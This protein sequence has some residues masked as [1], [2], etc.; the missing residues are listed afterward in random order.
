[1]VPDRMIVYADLRWSWQNGAAGIDNVKRELLRRAPAD[2]TIVELPIG[3]RPGS[4]L[5]PLAIAA[6]I[7]SNRASAM[8]R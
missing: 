4:A 6:A 1:M 5:S 8:A 3:V 2:A 7:A